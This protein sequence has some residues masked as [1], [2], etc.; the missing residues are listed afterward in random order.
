MT[1]SRLAFCP[2]TRLLTSLS[3]M[4]VVAV[5]TQIKFIIGAFALS[6][7]LL[8]FQKV[9]W[10]KLFP[11]LLSINCFLLF[12]WF[13]V[14]FTTPGETY[15]TVGSF[16]LTKEGI[17]LSLAVTLKCNA[18][19]FLFSVL[20]KSTSLSELSRAMTALGV[21]SKLATLLMLTVRHL[22]FFS[23]IQKKQS[24]AAVLRGF[25]A[26]NSL[27]TYR[28]YGAMLGSLFSRI[29]RKNALMHET[30]LLRGFQG[31]WPKQHVVA[32]PPKEKV[33][34]SLVFL[35]SLLFFILDRC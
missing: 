24:E 13:F 21:S 4:V 7:A 25:Q 15:A 17:E 23:S 8:V 35:L 5:L 30:L 3:L 33:L 1:Q 9:P 32:I 19:F 22:T 27:A 11:R 28:T 26:K 6:F 31:Q 16:A 12:V 29:V 2:Q 20:L 10:E 34:C 14:P 18:I